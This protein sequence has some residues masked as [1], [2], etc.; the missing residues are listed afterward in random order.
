L[1][2]F[3]LV[4][5]LHG[6]TFASAP[7]QSHAEDTYS[8][9]AKSSTTPVSFKVQTNS[10]GPISDIKDIAFSAL[11]LIPTQSI[12]WTDQGK[13][14][15]NLKASE[16]VPSKMLSDTPSRFRELGLVV[17]E[18][19]YRRLDVEATL[20]NRKIVYQALEF[21]WQLQDICYL[22]DPVFDQID[23]SVSNQAIRKGQKLVVE[24]ETSIPAEPNKAIQ[25]LNTNRN[26]QRRKVRGAISQTDW[27]VFPWWSYSVQVPESEVSI[28]CVAS[29]S[30]CNEVVAGDNDR[31]RISTSGLWNSAC[32]QEDTR[33]SSYS[34]GTKSGANASGCNIR[35]NAS[36]SISY[37]YE[38]D[39][40][41][42]DFNATW[43]NSGILTGH[44]PVL[45]DKCYWQ[46]TQ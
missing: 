44:S 36:A 6:Q 29:G 23:S 42:W 32:D 16:P 14:F 28:T 1:L 25:C 22:I 19:T 12:E 43:P 18:G 45:R 21:C 9:F 40:G 8:A 38:L 35:W 37:K 33:A 26:R 13:S 10:S 41:T 11:F 30:V 24:R 46:A 15:S 3:V 34:D 31:P 5:T 39:N 2:A 27:R 20:E 4:A 17:D 7:G